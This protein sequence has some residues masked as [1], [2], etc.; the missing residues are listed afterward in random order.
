MPACSSPPNRPPPDV[1][2][3]LIGEVAW[4]KTCLVVAASAPAGSPTRERELALLRAAVVEPRLAVDAILERG[5]ALPRE[6][7]VELRMCEL[8]ISKLATVPSTP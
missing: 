8:A 6:V 7:L 3:R 5:Q 1:I 4:A 2:D